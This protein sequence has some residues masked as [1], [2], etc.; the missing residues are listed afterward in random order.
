M[1]APDPEIAKQV[2]E[3]AAGPFEWRNFVPTLWMALISGIGGFVSWYG[4]IRDGNARPFNIIELVGEVV[5][6]TAV[7]LVTFWICRGFGVNDWLTAAGV[8]I[9]GHMGARAI[10]LA[11]KALERKFEGLVK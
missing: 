7:G 10:F 4:K 2:V 1:P 6:S 3:A 5:V 11:E 8:A 9:S